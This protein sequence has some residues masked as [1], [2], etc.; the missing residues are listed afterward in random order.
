MKIKLQCLTTMNIRKYLYCLFTEIIYTRHY[1]YKIIIYTNIVKCPIFSFIRYQNR[2]IMLNKVTKFNLVSNLDLLLQ[3]K[4]RI[5]TG[6]VNNN[7]IFWTPAPIEAT[8]PCDT[9]FYKFPVQGIELKYFFLSLVQTSQKWHR[10]LTL[11]KVVARQCAWDSKLTF[12][13][14]WWNILVLELNFRSGRFCK[15]N[16]FQNG[17]LDH[18]SWA[19][20]YLGSPERTTL[21]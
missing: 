9:P 1:H 14:N 21:N 19:T 5:S 7:G 6:C 16:H 10:E 20:R 12:I 3:N 18:F 11:Q 4:K 13:R 2:Q 15:N 8:D 17:C